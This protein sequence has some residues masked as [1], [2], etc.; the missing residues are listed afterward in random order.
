M[1]RLNDNTQIFKSVSTL[2]VY[3]LATVT[4]G[5]TVTTA[6]LAVSASVCS[7]SATTSFASADPVFII[8]DGGVELNACGAPAVAMPLQYKAAF[9]QSAGAQFVEAVKTPLGYLSEDGV[10]FSPSQS[11]NA[12]LS[13]NSA[14]PLNY[15]SGIAEL[16][17]SFG[18]LAFSGLNLQT[19]LGITESEIGA[20]TPTDP[21]QVSVGGASIGTQGV[22]CF[23]LTGLLH[24]LQNFHMDFL[25]ARVEVSGQTTMNRSGPAIY[26]CTIKFTSMVKRQWT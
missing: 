3:R 1:P 6:A 7:V 25:N 24:S 21:Y 18:L 15:I 4:P 12:I 14:T 19:I 22:Q 16:S 13:A 11:L 10:S 26:P 9:A 20:G 2:D 8:G 5:S 23:R 17:V